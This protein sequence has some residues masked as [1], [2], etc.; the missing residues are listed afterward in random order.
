M[1]H[2]ESRVT[3]LLV[4]AHALCAQ[5]TWPCLASRG[6]RPHTVWGA[7]RE[8]GELHRV[9]KRLLPD[10]AWI[11]DEDDPISLDSSMCTDAMTE[12]K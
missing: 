7:Q 10:G 2:L 4:W 5:C 8:Q 12:I 11:S 6:R 9:K 3:M 1:W